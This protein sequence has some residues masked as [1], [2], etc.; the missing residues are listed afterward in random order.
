MESG[1]LFFYV[2]TV[3]IEDDAKRITSKR[4]TEKAQYEGE[5]WQF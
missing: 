2:V 5:A 1:W 4:H 3:A